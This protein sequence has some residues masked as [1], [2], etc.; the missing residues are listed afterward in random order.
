VVVS[1]VTVAVT[2][3]PFNQ[4]AEGDHEQSVSFG[5]LLQLSSTTPSKP[6]DGVTVMV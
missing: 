4:T 2:V 3:E 6:L 1:T 5:R